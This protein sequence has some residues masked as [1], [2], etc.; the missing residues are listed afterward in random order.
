M[1]SEP[2]NS[3][4]WPRYLCA[5]SWL[6]PLL[7]L[8]FAAE[9][10]GSHTTVINNGP[11]SNRV[12]MVFLGDGYTAAQINTVYP[13]HIVAMTNHMFNPPPG[14]I[15]R[16]PYPRYKN[17]FNVHRV[18]VLSVES[19]ADAVPENIFRDTALDAQYF[20]DGATERLLYINETKAN[21]ALNAGLTD[22]G[23][24]AD[25]R[26]LTV[27]DT[28]YGGGGGTYAVYAGG[29]GSATE[30]ALH[31]LGHS[32]NGLADEYGGFTLPYG[33][34]EPPE[35]NVTKNSMGAKWSH[36]LGHNQPGIGVIGAYQGARYYN[37][38]LYRPSQDSKMRSLDRPFDAISREKIVLDIYNIVDPLD[39]F[40][41]NTQPLLD[42]PELWVDPIDANVI[43][44]QWIVNGSIVAGASGESFTL[45]DYGF[46]PGLYTVQAR[47]FDPTGFDPV[48]GWVR[49]N[50]DQLE[51][52]VTWTVT[53]TVPEPGTII[54]AGF[55]LLML[56]GACVR[57]TFHS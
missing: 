56:V 15:T 7:A 9:A 8:L 3:P 5:W 53:Q 29:N 55:G 27:N 16:D 23:F 1:K 31:E 42:P 46:G 40:L 33:G 17:Y 6:A 57:N 47:A 32:F 28:R 22:A 38:G 43:D 24:N 35:I 14:V 19:G 51:Q 49:R 25:I 26:L 54:L 20:F 39:G 18:N 45:L 2:G 4:I 44:L 36:W 34:A 41:N 48:N 13:A 11:N 50:Q 10:W 30:V 37:T 12:N 21:N 52:F